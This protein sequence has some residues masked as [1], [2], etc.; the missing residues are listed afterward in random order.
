MKWVKDLTIFRLRWK[1]EPETPEPFEF[2]YGEDDT[3]DT[4]DNFGTPPHFEHY[5]GE[6]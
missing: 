5:H 3:L 2:Y 1:V 4:E 6:D